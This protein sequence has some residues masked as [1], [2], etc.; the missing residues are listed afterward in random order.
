M[1]ESSFR[2]LD[3]WKLAMDLAVDVYRTTRKFP[4]EETYGA[5][6]QLRRAASSVAANIAEGNG[7]EHL[8]DYLRHLSIARGSL[9]E[10]ETFIELA[11]R[12][13]YVTEHECEA[14]ISLHNR[15][16]MMLNKLI[17]ALKRRR[18]TNENRKNSKRS[19]SETKTDDS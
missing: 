10:S 7:R 3:T 2:S 4:R 17:Q 12:L 5:T 11:R 8:G 6:S 18:D 13:E 9:A 19:R 15:V 14:L 16:G 1:S